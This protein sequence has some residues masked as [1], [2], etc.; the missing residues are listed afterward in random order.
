MSE[1]TTEFMPI[2]KTKHLLWI[3]FLF[4]SIGFAQKKPIV[5]VEADTTQIK[6]GEQINLTVS[7]K[8]D[9]TRSVNFPELKQFGP[10]EIIEES[11]IDTFREKDLFNLIKKYGLTKFDSGS[12]VIPSFPIIISNQSYPTDSIAVTVLDVEVDT[13]KQKMYDIKDIIAVHPISNFWK[14]FWWTLGTLLVLGAIAFYF[15]LKNKAKK[16][17]EEDLPPY[18]K[19]ISE[20]QKLDNFSLHEQN[21]YKHYYSKVTDVLKIYYES[22][23]HVDVMECTSDELLEKIELLI[24]SEQINLEKST[25]NKLRETLKTSDLVKFAKYSNTFEDARSDRDNILEFIS[26]THETLPEPTEE[27]LMAG[28]QRRVLQAKRRKKRR[29]VVAASLIGLILLGTGSVMIAKYGFRSTMDTLFRKTSKLMLDGDWVYSEYGYPPVGIETPEVLTQVKVPIPAGNEK[30]IVSMTNYA[31]GN[32]GKDLYVVVNHVNFNPQLEITNDQVSEL[33]AGELKQRFGLEDFQLKSEDITI[34]EIN[35]THKT[36]N[37]FKDSV[38]YQ[39][40]VYTFFAKP[41]LRQIVV[42]YKKDD[43]YYPEI[44]KRIFNSI[45]LL[46]GE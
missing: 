10:F 35:G 4:G 34:D 33:S 3:L 42:V 17:A 37:F 30:A 40:D 43:R 12:Y 18:E 20:L 22:E 16:E 7:V 38:G 19:A 1:K 11:P 27:E 23:V 9:S 29:L 13:L 8:V 45:K 2:F 15:W 46:K 31:Y 26:L 14:Y 39:F 28:E 32:L 5:K 44:S 25:L 24:D 41:S 21:D 6:I 36:G